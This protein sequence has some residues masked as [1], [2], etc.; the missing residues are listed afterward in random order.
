MPHRPPCPF[1]LT[2]PE[3]QFPGMLR[4]VLRD[5]PFWLF[6]VERPDSKAKPKFGELLNR[7]EPNTARLKTAHFPGPKGGSLKWDEPVTCAATAATAVAATAVV[8]TA[9][10]ATPVAV[11]A[12]EDM[13]TAVAATATTGSSAQR[14]LRP[15]RRLR[16]GVLIRKSQQFT[17]F[18]LVAELGGLS[19]WDALG[20]ADEVQA[21]P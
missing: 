19:P 16:C 3:A 4:G 9:V 21:R 8:A 12:T 7:R 10:V 1:W 17:M 15:Q 2:Q 14:Q 5:E 18:N 6:G 11:A 13:V 20:G